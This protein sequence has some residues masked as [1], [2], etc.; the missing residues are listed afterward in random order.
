[1]AIIA[2]LELESR[3]F[4]RALRKSSPRAGGRA[5]ASH[6]AVYCSGPGPE[7]AARAAARAIEAGARALVS[8]GLAG[9][10][11]ADAEPGT[12]LLPARVV[13]AAGAFESD[14]LW[15]ERLAAML[16]P[17]FRVLEAP[18]VSVDRVV[19]EVADK[20]ALAGRFGAA[21]VDLESAA[22]ARAAARA[23]LPFVALRVVADGPSDAL[24]A[25]VESLVTADGR[26]RLVGLLGLFAAP[27]QIP[28]LIRLGCRSSRAR[29][30]LA[31][32]AD[33]VA[34]LSMPSAARESLE[35]ST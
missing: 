8:F 11:R 10:L 31:Q 5:A 24:P 23:R 14:A 17:G 30:V 20:A 4:E 34:R 15:R 1:V 25:K 22:I 18:L 27:G 2:A 13:D 12:V 9:G 29:A 6:P 16:A 19:T 7:R 35:T 3:I 33:R 28:A 32:V 21:A 26:T